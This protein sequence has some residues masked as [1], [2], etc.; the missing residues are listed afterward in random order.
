MDS[1]E[2]QKEEKIESSVIEMEAETQTLT[3]SFVLT[4]VQFETGKWNLLPLAFSA[5]DSLAE[6][7]IDHEDYTL[8]IIGHTDD[9]GSF[10]N[11]RMLSEKRAKAVLQYLKKK[12]VKQDRM[13]ATG[14]GDTE[15][16]DDN[17]YEEGRQRNRRV[18][19]R[20]KKPL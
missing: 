16:V 6:Y 2:N 15:P 19:F 1:C 4:N 5:L 7:L 3:D 20:V 11:N 13:E 8:E 17:G 9:Q 10:D 12:G 14:K 18:E